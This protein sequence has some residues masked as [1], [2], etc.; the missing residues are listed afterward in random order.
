[1]T[2]RLFAA[3]TLALTIAT[4]AHAQDWRLRLEQENQ[5]NEMMRLEQQQRDQRLEMMRQEA[6]QRNEMSRQR[7]EQQI[8]MQRLQR[9]NQPGYHLGC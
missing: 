4:S 2:M 8:E 9:C 5:H 6:D 1:M 3:L 7:D